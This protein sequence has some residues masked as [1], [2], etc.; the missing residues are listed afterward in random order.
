MIECYFRGHYLNTAACVHLE[1]TPNPPCGFFDLADI[2]SS[3]GITMTFEDNSCEDE[4]MDTNG[5]VC[6]YLKAP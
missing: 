3:H 5:G 2:H 6:V 4:F 1:L